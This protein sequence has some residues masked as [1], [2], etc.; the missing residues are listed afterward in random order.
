MAPGALP[1]TPSRRPCGRTPRRRPAESSQR[2]DGALGLRGAFA[3][4]DGAALGGGLMAGRNKTELFANL[5][6]NLDAASRL[7]L[8]GAQLKQK[9]D[10]DF[11]SG[12]A[13]ADMTQ[14]AFGASYRY[15]LGGSLVDH[16]EFTAYAARTAS[17]DLGAVD[18]TVEQ[19]EGKMLFCGAWKLLERRLKTFPNI[20][21]ISI[22]K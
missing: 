22:Q 8:T 11:P 1:R 12:K 18:Y 17:R 20:F 9:L 14:N 13:R 19:G 21:G 15:R 16:A 3:L 5:G 6:W 4:A 10:F 7:V 2:T